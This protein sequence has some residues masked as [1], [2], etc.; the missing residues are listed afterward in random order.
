M[1]KEFNKKNKGYSVCKKLKT[2]K[3]ITL[4]ALIITVIVLLILVAVS[5]SILLKSN[6]IGVAEKSTTKYNEAA[7]QEGSLN[8]IKGNGKD[9]DYYLNKTDGSK[10]DNNKDD[11]KKDEVTNWRD[12]TLAERVELIK[13]TKGKMYVFDKGKDLYTAK[14][15]N[16][17]FG[18]RVNNNE[19]VFKKGI[20]ECGKVEEIFNKAV[21]LGLVETYTEEETQEGTQ[22]SEVITAELKEPSMVL[23]DFICRNEEQKPGGYIP[24]VSS[25]DYLITPNF[26]DWF[27][28]VLPNFN[29]PGG[30]FESILAWLD[31][32]YA[33][34]GFTSMQPRA[35]MHPTTT[36]TTLGQIYSQKIQVV[37]KTNFVKAIKELGLD[38]SAYDGVCSHPVK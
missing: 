22:Y 26:E 18:E 38:L 27:D 9:L 13:N 8:G 10:D 11:D 15:E 31:E 14:L 7:K 20:C 32:D 3:G 30:D 5:I 24:M 1:N 35:F 36:L 19:V 29:K 4:V 28:L 21:E 34:M 25:L 12:L 23:Y 16:E 33:K 37:S 2:N 17:E 6:L